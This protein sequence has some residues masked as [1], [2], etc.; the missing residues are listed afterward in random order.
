ML[1][2]YVHIV[3]LEPVFVTYV[4]IWKE[5][6]LT[7]FDLV[8]WCSLLLYFL[9]TLLLFVGKEVFII[10]NNQGSIG[11]NQKTFLVAKGAPYVNT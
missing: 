4:L 1:C 8:L 6:F 7:Y 10:N 11:Q 3:H 2:T 5:T 9:V